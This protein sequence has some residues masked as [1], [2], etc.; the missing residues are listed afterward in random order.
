MTF[1]TASKRCLL[2]LNGARM[3]CLPLA[4]EGIGVVGVL[5]AVERL[6]IVSPFLCFGVAFTSGFV[7]CNFESV[8][9]RV[10]RIPFSKRHQ[11]T[12]RIRWICMYS[13]SMNSTCSGKVRC[14]LFASAWTSLKSFSGSVTF[15]TVFISFSFVCARRYRRLPWG[16]SPWDLNF[17]PLV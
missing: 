8:G 17:Q 13:V 10:V 5:F 12:P 3:L 15:F 14:S 11:I 7:S 16:C 4:A 9:G 2:L 1:V 6:G